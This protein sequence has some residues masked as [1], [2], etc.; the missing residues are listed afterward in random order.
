MPYAKIN[1][2]GCEV[3]HG[4]LVKVRI[5]MFLALDDVRYDER[6]I[7]NEELGIFVLV[8]FHSHFLRF[9]PNVSQDEIEATI[10]HHLPNF[11]AAWIQ[12]YDK[13]KC[14]MRHGWD[15]ETRWKVIGRPRCYDREMSIGQLKQRTQKCQAKLDIILASNLIIHSSDIGEIFPSTE[16]DIGPGA[17]DANNTWGATWTMLSTVNTANDSGSIDTIDIFAA[18]A[19]TGMKVGTFSGSGTDYDD[20]DYETIGDVINEEEFTGLDCDVETGDYLGAYWATGVMEFLTSPQAPQGDTYYVA[21]DKFGGAS[22]TYTLYSDGDLSIY[23]TG[24]TAGAA[25]TKVIDEIVGITETSRYLIALLK[26]IADV[27]GIIESSR[28]FG[29]ISQRVG[30]VIGINEAVRS[31][32]AIY[33]RIGETIGIPEAIRHFKTMH[34]IISEIVG[35]PEIFLPHRTMKRLISEAEGMIETTRGLRGLFQRVGETVSTIETTRYLIGLL[36]RINESI[37]IIES[38]RSFKTISQRI[39]EIIGIPEIIVN[40]RSMFRIISETIGIIESTRPLREL[41]RRI[42]ELEGIKETTKYFRGIVQRISESEA[43]KE[44]TRPFRQLYR[45]VGEK[46]AIN[47]SS[48]YARVMIRLIAELEAIAEFAV[49]TREMNRIANEVEAINESTRGFRQLLRRVVE[50][51][52]ITESV[53]RYLGGA[54][55][56]IINEELG[57]KENIITQKLGIIIQVI[58]ESIALTETVLDIIRRTI[59]EI[60]VKLHKRTLQLMLHSRD[61]AVRLNKRTLNIRLR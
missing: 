19:I 59:A 15:V 9:E 28:R 7:W 29:A 46:V 34:R 30:E 4:G 32:R 24:E 38:T 17:I 23:G 52:G 37:G 51:I 53:V 27:V 10:N 14:G 36:K 39:G 22:N 49:R 16:I 58:N 43:I 21:G 55:V 57:I 42:G 6:Y 47:E 31:F 20:R 8:P 61:L 41:F 40:P 11:Y 35:I 12:E 2:S 56:K 54:L 33:Q 13:L 18:G 50:T 5:D 26:R 25:L 44:T 45:R 3:W 1:P 48:L 60:V